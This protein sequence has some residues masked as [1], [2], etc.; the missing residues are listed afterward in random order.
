MITILTAYIGLWAFITLMVSTPGPANL[1]LMSAGAAYGFK[2]HIGFMGGL[3]L[4]KIAVNLFVAFGFGAILVTVPIAAQIFAFISAAYL[5]YLAM[6][7]WNVGT[8]G[9][10]PLRPLGFVSGVFVHP[11]SPKAW[12]MATLAYSQFIVGYESAF[13]RYALAPLSFM[14]IQLIFHSLWCWLGTLLKSQ[15][16]TSPALNR[17]LILLTIAVVIWAL[18]Q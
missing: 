5:C 18:L 9:T 8:K 13:E 6:R 15:L 4:G 1:L 3:L 17:G 12:V 2:A 7:G 10:A 16:G 14:V 11:L